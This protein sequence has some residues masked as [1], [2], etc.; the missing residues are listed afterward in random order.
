[1][2]A[3][4]SNKPRKHHFVQAEHLR[5][6]V[7][8]EGFLW[9]YAKSGKQF[10]GTPEGIFKKKD[11][12]SFKGI[13]GLDT[14][15]EDY[16][17][18]IENDC[19]PAIKRTILNEKIT[20]QDIPNLATYLSLSKFR[21]PSLQK[22]IVD[23]HHQLV[24][25]E[26]GILEGQG[27][28]DSLRPNPI[29]PTKSLSHL[30]A[31]GTV[32]I[33]INNIVYIKAVIQ[34]LE[35]FQN[36][37]ANGFKWCLVKS[38]RNRFILGDHPLTYVH[39]GRDPGAYGIP[40][41]GKTCEMSFPLSKSICLVGF[42]EKQIGDFESEDVVD[43]INKRQAIFACRQ[44]A[45]SYKNNNLE[46]LV[47]RYKKHGF[48]TKSDVLGPYHLLRSGIYIL[49]GEKAVREMHPLIQTIPILDMSYA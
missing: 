37:L 13:S 46:G 30:I 21:N 40:P 4:K 24:N 38:T 45:S 43:E 33:G 49:Q 8:D 6:F 10:S 5:Q 44:I 26:I 18:E 39:P 25:S 23:F 27:Q 47:R 28:F 36:L 42:W 35:Q 41:G 48:Q 29:D 12:N 15:F 34:Q 3:M 17:T 19:W 22:G 31:E 14:S 1:L 16:I 20:Q 9:I 7:N 11:L 2:K 32:V